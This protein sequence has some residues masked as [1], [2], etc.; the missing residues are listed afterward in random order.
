MGKLTLHWSY[1][2]HSWWVWSSQNQTPS[3]NMPA[4]LTFGFS[5]ADSIS[6]QKQRKAILSPLSIPNLDSTAGVCYDGLAMLFM[7]SQA[8]PEKATR[9]LLQNGSHFIMAP[10]S[11]LH[12]AKRRHMAAYSSCTCTSLHMCSKLYFTFNLTCLCLGS[13]IWRLLW[14]NSWRVSCWGGGSNAVGRSWTVFCRSTGW[15]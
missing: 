11:I 9:Q 8:L 7:N 13:C 3:A 2:L 10:T 15:P 14:L 12:L 5:L 4:C 1:I 6:C